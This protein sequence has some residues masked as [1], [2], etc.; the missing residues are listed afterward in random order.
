M[1]T[2]RARIAQL[3]LLL[4][5]TNI[6]TVIPQT[7]GNEVKARMVIVLLDVTP[8]FKSIDQALEQIKAVIQRLGPGDEFLLVEVGEPPFLPEKKVKFQA[9]M[10]S[11]PERLLSPSKNIHE[12]KQRQHTLDLIWAKVRGRQKLML[13]SLEQPIPLQHGGTDLYAALEYAAQR[14]GAAKENRPKILLIY[15]DLVQ[16]KGVPTN[17]PPKKGLAGF[18]QA[19]VSVFFVPWESQ[20]AWEGKENK[21]RAYFEACHVKSVAMSEPAQSQTQ[22]PLKESGIPKTPK[23]PFED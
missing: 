20:E 5:V 21:W 22:T 16:D 4:L 9:V 7:T 14:F 2:R 12:W 3:M 10:P 18:N 17:D 23:S 1:K 13:A 8:S 19:D 6:N 11:V 15:S